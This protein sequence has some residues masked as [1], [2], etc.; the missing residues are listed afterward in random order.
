METVFLS[1]LNR[2]MAAG[3]LILAA[4]VDLHK[5]EDRTP[6]NRLFLTR[7]VNEAAFGKCWKD[8]GKAPHILLNAFRSAVLFLKLT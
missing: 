7:V 1:L 6:E 8:M 4:C 3:W 2:S 5:R